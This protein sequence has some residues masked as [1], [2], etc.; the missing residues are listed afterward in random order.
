[1]GGMRKLIGMLRSRYSHQ[2]AG[3]TARVRISASKR[4]FP[5]LK[6]VQ[7]GSGVHP[8]SHLIGTGV[9]PRA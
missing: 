2:A 3:W 1:M 5:L 6:I 9:V 7:T 8:A 4:V